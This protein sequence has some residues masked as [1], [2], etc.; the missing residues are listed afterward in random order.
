M[1]GNI[2]LKSFGEWVRLQSI[3]LIEL[4]MSNDPRARRAKYCLALRAEAAGAKYCPRRSVDTTWLPP[5]SFAPLNKRQRSG[6]G[7]LC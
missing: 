4:M 3:E 7:D 2:E 1:S 5:G 6:Q